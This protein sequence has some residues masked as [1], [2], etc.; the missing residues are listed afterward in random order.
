MTK[1]GKQRRSWNN[2]TRI[3]V[4]LG[5]M[6]RAREQDAVLIIDNKTGNVT[7]VSVQAAYKIADALVDHA[8]QLDRKDQQ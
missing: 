4:T 8:E 1:P 6:H 3:H 5:H 7:P 2:G